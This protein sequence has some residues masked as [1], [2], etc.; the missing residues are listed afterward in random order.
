MQ[1]KYRPGARQIAFY[2]I[3]G[4]APLDSHQPSIRKE[5][6]KRQPKFP[7][8]GRVGRVETVEGAEL[9]GAKKLIRYL[10]QEPGGKLLL[11]SGGRGCRQY[12][13]ECAPGSGLRDGIGY[14]LVFCVAFGFGCSLVAAV[15]S[16]RVG[17]AR[18]ELVSVV[19]WGG[20]FVGSR[21]ALAF[22]F[23]VAVV[24]GWGGAACAAVS[25]YLFL[26]SAARSGSPGRD[27][28][29]SGKF[30]G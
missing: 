24:V 13:L 3:S 14:G 2:P 29:E 19:P 8:L 11:P 30:P 21:L 23:P 4:L 25:F 9:R 12:I 15:S 18:S 22:V 6:K 17:G 1:R 20:G 28:S 26:G 16:C 7:T 5:R 27:L 10:K